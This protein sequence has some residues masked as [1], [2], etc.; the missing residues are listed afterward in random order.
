MLSLACVGASLVC[1]ALAHSQGP[2]EIRDTIW[3]T[4]DLEK[5]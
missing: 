3:A 5:A 4:L 2:A 1:L